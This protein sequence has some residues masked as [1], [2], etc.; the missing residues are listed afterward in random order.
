[1]ITFPMAD[2]EGK[3]LRP[4][5]IIPRLKKILPNVN[6]EEEIGNQVKEALKLML[7]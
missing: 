3:S 2:F 7:K 6:K 1:M 4:S 5:I